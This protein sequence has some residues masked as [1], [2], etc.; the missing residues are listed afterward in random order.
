MYNEYILYSC[1][2]K[3]DDKHISGKGSDQG[4]DSC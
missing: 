3:Y 2:M 1:W 4:V